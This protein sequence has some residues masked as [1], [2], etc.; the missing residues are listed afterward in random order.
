MLPGLRMRGVYTNELPAL[1]RNL[2][3]ELLEVSIFLRHKPVV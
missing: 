2:L 3:L 1:K